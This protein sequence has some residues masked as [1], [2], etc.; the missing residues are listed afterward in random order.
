MPVFHLVTQ[1]VNHVRPVVI[2]R[3]LLGGVGDVDS[4]KRGIDRAPQKPNGVD[5]AIHRGGCERKAEFPH[6]GFFAVPGLG[7][8]TAAT[9]KGGLAEGEGGG[10][11]E[12]GH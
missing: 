9:L 3:E 4:R 1:L 7:E 6:Q 8:L 12:P 11:I 2:K 5:L 10:G